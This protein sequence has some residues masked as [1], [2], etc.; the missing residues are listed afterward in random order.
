VVPRRTADIVVEPLEERHLEGLSELNRRRGRPGVD[1]R[2]RDHL[3]RGLG[4]FV[5]MQD[6]RIVAY[7][8]WVD[9]AEG[10]RH[11]DLAWLGESLQIEPGDA[12]GS[13]F[14]ILPDARGAGVAGEFLYRV[15]SGLAE[16]GLKRLWGYLASGNR[17]ARW[18]YSSRG[19]LPIGD[20]TIR[21]VG[22]RR[23]V[24][25]MPQLES[26]AT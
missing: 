5:G 3:D 19:Y 15:E 24:T 25:G 16:R 7:Y 18:V 14:Y 17:E 1:R 6:G 8:W 9:C 12:Y 4:G 22:S 21:R 26:S 10:D 23:R 13:D 11:P 2:F 20:L